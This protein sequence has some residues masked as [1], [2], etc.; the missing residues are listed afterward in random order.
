MPKYQ[1]KLHQREAGIIVETYTKHVDSCTALILIT[2]L[3]LGTKTTS[4]YI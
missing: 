3:F 2:Y 1:A 4:N